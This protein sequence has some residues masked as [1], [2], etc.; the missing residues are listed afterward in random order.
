[1]S[2]NISSFPVFYFIY[3]CIL[4]YMS[5]CELHMQVTEESRGHQIPWTWSPRWLWIGMWVREA[6]PGFSTSALYLSHLTS[7]GKKLSELYSQ[8]IFNS[9]FL[10]ISCQTIPPLPFLEWF[11]QRTLQ[12][13]QH[14][15]S[16]RWQSVYQQLSC[17]TPCSSFFPIHTKLKGED[18]LIGFIFSYSLSFLYFVLSWC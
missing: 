7:H 2:T 4:T 6:K 5:L 1:M 15:A 12:T 8:T 17:L 16:W 13:C 10:H 14:R 3:V 18:C 9:H 11:R